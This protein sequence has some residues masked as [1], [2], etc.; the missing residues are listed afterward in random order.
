MYKLYF[1]IILMLIACGV[2]AQNNAKEKGLTALTPQL[3]E[4]QLTFLASDW[5]EGREVGT[6][7]NHLAGDYIKSMFQYNGLKAMGDEVNFVPN[8]YEKLQNLPAK[9]YTDYFQKFEVIE[10]NASDKHQLVLKRENGVTYSYEFET[11]FAVGLQDKS[12]SINSDIVF[13]GY[14]IVEEKYTNVEGKWVVC[15]SGSEKAPNEKGMLQHKMNMAKSNGAIGV[16]YYDSKQ[17]AAAK[18]V[19]NTPFRYNEVTYEGDERPSSFYDKR[20]A[21]PQNGRKR[22]PLVQI[23]QRVIS[24]LLSDTSVDLKDVSTWNNQELDGVSL[25]L[26]LK[27]NT[28]LLQ[29]RNV[30]GM[31]EGENPNEIVVVGAHYDHL[32][33]HNGRIWNGADDNASGVVAVMSIARACMATGV[34]PKRTIVFACWDGEERGLLG[35]RYFASTID[36]PKNYVAYLNFDMIGRDRNPEKT[37]KHVLMFYTKAFKD[38]ERLNK[39]HVNKYSLGIET[40]YRPWENPVGGS[41]NASFARLGIPIFWYHT[42][43]H[44]DYH[45]ATDHAS[46][47]NWE[48]MLEI[49]KVSYLNVWELANQENRLSKK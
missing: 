37:K 19:K 31:I 48:K 8:R 47:I 12:Q 17:R 18:W 28:R 13:V 5:T 15:I 39:K 46:L 29:A 16:L 43:G 42:D 2:V 21:L 40:E 10:I 4:S 49:V 7:G 11:D 35:S 9:S 1:G 25:L 14:G 3:V 20:V 44:P 34:K 24:D 33:M 30:L 6:K 32:G 45:K 23:S 22:L 26:K 41:D 38:L 27:S 36:N